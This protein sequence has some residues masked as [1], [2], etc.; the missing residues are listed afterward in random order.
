[1]KRK[2]LL[3]TS[4]GSLN[5]VSSWICDDRTF[6]IALIYYPEE[7]TLETKRLL[8]SYADYLFF[9]SGF[10]YEI[11]KR[12]FL[13]NPELM[14]Y[15]YFWMPD[16]DV[17]LVKGTTNELFAAAN[18]YHLGLAQ[19]SARKKN[20]SWK[21]LRNKKGYAIRYTN[22]VEVMCP[23]FSKKSLSQCIDSFSYT[24]SGWGLDFLWPTLIDEK[25]AIIDSHIIEHTK[26]I[27]L[28][29]GALYKKLIEETGK[30]PK[31]E[32]LELTS[33]FNLAQQP[34]ILSVVY[35]KN[36]VI[37]W[38]KKALSKVRTA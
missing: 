15:E 4:I 28:E 33:E 26:K 34:A 35:K 16:D 9:E 13:A 1:M 36:S 7:I 8:E 3:I 38:L 6:D 17:N 20:T 2:N 22:F 19:P 27:N 31:E 24:K 29:G 14:E 25:V 23:I 5:C 12:V 37:G 30:T 10:K 11:L 32:L 21:L 18:K